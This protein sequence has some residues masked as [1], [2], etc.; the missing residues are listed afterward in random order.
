M[1]QPTGNPQGRQSAADR[2]RDLY[3]AREQLDME[4]AAQLAQLGETYELIGTQEQERLRLIQR[5]VD[6]AQLVN[7]Q[8]AGGSRV[9][10]RAPGQYGV[11]PPVQQVPGQPG[12]VQQ[13][14]VQQLTPTTVEQYYQ[15]IDNDRR[16]QYRAA[17]N[18]SIRNAIF[19]SLGVAFVSLLVWWALGDSLLGNSHNGGKLWLLGTV[20]AIGLTAYVI[21][22]RQ[23]NIPQN[24]TG[25]FRA[26]TEP[27][28]RVPAQPSNSPVSPPAGF[29]T[30]N[31]T[32]PAGTPLQRMAD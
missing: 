32:T 24:P 29:Y 1:T 15:R 11:Q 23:P 6:A 21:G 5:G 30:P 8:A 25:D 16:R 9:F 2:I 20:L 12:Q 17:R 22:G 31:G 19:A 10:M 28:Y 18:R 27:L 13:A 4:A 3:Q 7:V 14:P 26:P